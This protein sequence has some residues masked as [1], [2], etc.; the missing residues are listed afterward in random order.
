[1]DHFLPLYS[2]LG[3]INRYL[4]QGVLEF[5]EIVVYCRLNCKQVP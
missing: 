5:D 1:M 2:L 3:R 4:E